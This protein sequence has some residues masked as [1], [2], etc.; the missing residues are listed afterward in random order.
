MSDY[1]KLYADTFNLRIVNTLHQVI[2]FE[3]NDIVGYI[4]K[5]EP[6]YFNY[7]HRETW[8]ACKASDLISAVLNSIPAHG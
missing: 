4:S 5:S 7:K 3:A 6:K 2:L 8:S 1:V